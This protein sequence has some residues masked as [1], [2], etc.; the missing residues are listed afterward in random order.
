M[1]IELAERDMKFLNEEWV[2]ETISRI[3]AHLMGGLILWIIGTAI[4]NGLG[5]S[6][7]PIG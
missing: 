3:F 4:A 7:P 5:I 6:V 2:R 1:L